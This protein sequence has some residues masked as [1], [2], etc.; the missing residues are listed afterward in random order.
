MINYA[1]GKAKP[2]PS[3]IR[4]GRGCKEGSLSG[5]ILLKDKVKL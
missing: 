1:P 4:W 2:A 5:C 3:W